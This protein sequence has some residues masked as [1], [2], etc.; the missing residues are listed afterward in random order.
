MLIEIKNSTNRYVK[1][2]V[3]E[4]KELKLWN[5][6]NCYAK[7]IDLK[8]RDKILPITVF[9]YNTYFP[10][11]KKNYNEGDVIVV[12]GRLNFNQ[13]RS[14]IS[15]IIDDMKKE[16]IKGDFS[17]SKKLNEELAKKRGYF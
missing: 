9:N 1:N 2:L 5:N 17:T 10:D 13:K 4:L 12:S 11:F 6:T 7:L 15:I 8:D 3:G 14:E 16:N